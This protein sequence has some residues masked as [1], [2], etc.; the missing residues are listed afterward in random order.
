MFQMVMN[1][2]KTMFDKMLDQRKKEVPGF[3]I[4]SIK[5]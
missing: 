4:D 5:K 3:I 2:D 1:M